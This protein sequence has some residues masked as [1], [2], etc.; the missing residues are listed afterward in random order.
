M[1][2]AESQAM[3]LIP[4]NLEPEPHFRSHVRSVCLAVVAV[5]HAQGKLNP[6]DCEYGS[7]I[8]RMVVDDFKR[9]VIAACLRQMPLVKDDDGEFDFGPSR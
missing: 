1:I 3:D 5:R 2:L 9:D 8:W 4:R 6:R 7:E